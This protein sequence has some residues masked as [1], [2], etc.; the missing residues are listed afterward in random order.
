MKIDFNTANINVDITGSAPATDISSDRK[1]AVLH[2]TRNSDPVIDANPRASESDMSAIKYSGLCRRA[3]QSCRRHFTV[4]GIS[5][6]SAC[7]HSGRLCSLRGCHADRRVR[8]VQLGVS[9][10]IPA[11]V[12]L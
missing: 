10:G 9:A 5:F 2:L 11:E 8:F 7:V 1:F 6:H 12:R 4:G 3:S